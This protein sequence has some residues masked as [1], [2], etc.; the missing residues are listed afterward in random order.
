MPPRMTIPKAASLVITLSGGLVHTYLA[1]KLASS[2]ATLRAL[3]AETEYENAFRLD[4]LRVL[5]LLVA[6]YLIAASCISF[7]GF[8]GVLRARPSHVRLY[9]DCASADLAFTALLGLVAAA[10]A[11]HPGTPAPTCD[12]PELAPLLPLIGAVLAPFLP[13]QLA[14]DEAC[15]RYLTQL[16]VAA[17]AALLVLAVVR[18]HFLLAVN[19]HYAALLRQ[20][21]RAPDT[22]ADATHRIR[23]LPLPPRRPRRRRRLRPRPRARRRRRPRRDLG[24]RRRG[25]RGRRPARRQRRPHQARV[26][27]NTPLYIPS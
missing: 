3:E 10:V 26:D 27:L 2:W 25:G 17:A 5:F 13:A 22:E 9:R 18:V 15:E 1:L 7:L 6:L 12:A 14:P 21:Q 24:P 11:F 20:Q 8:S 19:T 16:G 23:L 4:G